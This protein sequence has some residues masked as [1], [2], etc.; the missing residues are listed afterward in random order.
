[1][2]EK[3]KTPQINTFNNIKTKIRNHNFVGVYEDPRDYLIRVAKCSSVDGLYEEI[4]SK[5]TIFFSFS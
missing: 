3:E 2:K 5:R 4:K 1:M